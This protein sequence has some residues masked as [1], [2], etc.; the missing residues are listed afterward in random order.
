MGSVTQV[1]VPLGIAAYFWFARRDFLAAGL[2]LAWA[3]TSARDAAVYIADAPYERLQLIGGEHDWAFVLGPAHLNLLDRAGLIAAAVTG[4]A[5][6]LVV[7]GILVCLLRL[8]RR[9]PS[10]QLPGHRSAWERPPVRF[11][12]LPENV[13]GPKQPD[14]KPETIYLP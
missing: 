8:I 5:V 1:L 13:L 11:R 2:C 10:T 12:H 4:L 6:T 7:A 3:G 9:E 14:D